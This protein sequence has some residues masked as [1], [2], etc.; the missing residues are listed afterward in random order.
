MKNSDRS[1][2]GEGTAFPRFLKVFTNLSPSPLCRL[3]FKSANN[4]P[5]DEE[6]AKDGKRFTLSLGERAGVR[7]GVHLIFFS[8]L[9]MGRV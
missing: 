4:L 9:F 1:R 8:E 2:A 5:G 3:R 6:L 7:A